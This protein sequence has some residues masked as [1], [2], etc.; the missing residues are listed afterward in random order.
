M[1]VYFS[2][3]DCHLSHERVLVSERGPHESER[4]HADAVKRAV[5]TAHRLMSPGCEG[6]ARMK[7]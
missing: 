4:E 1:T 6:E 2:C 5:E 7:A 3:P